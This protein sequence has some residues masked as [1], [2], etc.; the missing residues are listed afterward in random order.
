MKCSEC[1]SCQRMKGSHEIR[2]RCYGCIE[3]TPIKRDICVSESP[4]ETPPDWCPENIKK[5]TV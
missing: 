2:W 4:P 1:D 5:E 3:G